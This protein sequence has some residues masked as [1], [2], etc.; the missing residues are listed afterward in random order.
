MYLVETVLDTTAIMKKLIFR[1]TNYII[2]DAVALK[3][4]VI[5]KNRK[6]FSDIL[7]R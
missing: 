7:P 5:P 2:Y 3:I 6:R 4:I 1:K